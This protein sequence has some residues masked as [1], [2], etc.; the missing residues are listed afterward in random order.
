[1]AAGKDATLQFQNFHRPSVLHEY[2]SLRIGSIEK[3]SSNVAPQEQKQQS[4]KEQS[5]ESN[6]SQEEAITLDTSFT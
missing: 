4:K 2:E 3:S 6:E 1:M 5:A